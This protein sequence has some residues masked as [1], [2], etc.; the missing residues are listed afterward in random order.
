MRPTPSDSTS[1][2]GRFAYSPSILSRR[3]SV[4][5]CAR[6]TKCATRTFGEELDSDP[7]THHHN[8]TRHDLA[9]VHLVSAR[10]ISEAQPWSTFRDAETER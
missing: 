7:E 5:A 2:Q 4:S 9:H 6:L 3:A 1:P 10:R 8:E